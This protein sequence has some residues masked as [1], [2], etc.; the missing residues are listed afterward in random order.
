M[1]L[2]KF[3]ILKKQDSKDVKGH[4]KLDVR[5]SKARISL[6]IE[7]VEQD[8]DTTYKLYIVSDISSNFDQVEL[9][10][11]D[12][13]KRG[14][15]KL[16]L[17]FNANEIGNNKLDIA[18]F[19]ILILERQNNLTKQSQIILGGYIHKDDDTLSKVKSKSKTEEK[20]QTIETP[21]ISEAIETPEIPKTPESTQILKDDKTNTSSKQSQSINHEKLNLE[22]DEIEEL[23]SY[24]EHCKDY[25]KISNQKES[26]SKHYSEQIASYTTD[27]LKIF[28]QV[29]PFKIEFEDYKWWQIDYEEMNTHRGFLPYYSYILNSNYN[30]KSGKNI[31]CQSQIKKYNHYLFGMVEKQQKITHYVYAIPGKY[32]RKEHPY[33]GSTGF[34]T[35][36]EDKTG[37]GYWLSYIDAHTGNVVRPR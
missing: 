7:G 10:T 30:N 6:N 9:G 37:S 33:G 19:N 13:D 25:E 23:E 4:A 17:G 32:E 5:A 2:R 15:G 11:V 36:L 1:F 26:S 24:I 3:I 35:W 29:N 20:I 34:V 16:E 14:R 18:N 22:Q 12:V 31:T 21:E 8:G 28:K 27:I